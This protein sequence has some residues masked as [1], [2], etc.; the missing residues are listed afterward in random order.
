MASTPPPPHHLPPTVSPPPSPHT[1]RLAPMGSQLL[2][3]QILRVALPCLQA[4]AYSVSRAVK[5]CSSC[6]RER[7]Y[8]RRHKSHL[9]AGLTTI[10]TVVAYQHD[11]CN[12]LKCTA[13]RDINIYILACSLITRGLPRFTFEGRTYFTIWVC[14]V[15]LKNRGAW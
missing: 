9:T 14:T 10:L 1:H 13:I 7:F 3:L 4:M 15:S 5:S 2:L 8:R 6:A 11:K 12:P